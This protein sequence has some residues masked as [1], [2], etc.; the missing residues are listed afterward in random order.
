M[1]PDWDQSAEQLD[2]LQKYGRKGRTLFAHEVERGS[3]KEKNGRKGVVRT[4]RGEKVM[5]L[6]P[7]DVGV[8]GEKRA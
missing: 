2:H 7:P 1:R 8:R 3:A 5:K 4:D 6:R